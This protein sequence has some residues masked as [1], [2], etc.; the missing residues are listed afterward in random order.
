[1]VINPAIAWL[2]VRFARFIPDPDGVIKK[3]CI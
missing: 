3:D 1:M 2:I